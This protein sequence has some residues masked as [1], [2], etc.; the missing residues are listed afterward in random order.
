DTEIF[1]GGSSSSS[2]KPNILFVFDNSGSMSDPV[3]TQS[4]YDLSV[5]YTGSYD[6]RYI[7]VYTTSGYSRGKIVRANTRCQSMLDRLA[8]SGQ[9]LSARVARWRDVSG[10]NSD[11]WR[12]LNVSGGSSTDSSIT[13]CE[14]DQGTHGE[15]AGSTKL[16]AADGRDGPWSTRESD[17]IRWR[18]IERYNF[19]SANWLNWYFNHRV[20][21]TKTR[22]Q[23]VKDVAR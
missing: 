6:D 15:T 19:Y 11:D 3:V 23:V 16:Y 14:S 10:T 17:E 13:E 5:T 2:I 9:F 8:E 4:S 22:L 7:Y 12:S 18:D 1:F 21:T 20:V